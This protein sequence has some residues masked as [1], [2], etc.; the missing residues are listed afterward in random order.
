[1]CVLIYLK[2]MA[3][4]MSKEKSVQK[5]LH[6]DGLKRLKKIDSGD[7]SQPRSTLT[8]TKKKKQGTSID[9]VACSS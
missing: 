2:M 4:E 8:M 3:V 6:E 7:S 9:I 5:G 1:M